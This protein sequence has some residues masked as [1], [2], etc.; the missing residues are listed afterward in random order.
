M[1]NETSA[2]EGAQ[3]ESSDHAEV[4]DD[5]ND[6]LGFLSLQQIESR[7]ENEEENPIIKIPLEPGG[8][9]DDAPSDEEGSEP[10]D[11]ENSDTDTTSSYCSIWLHLQ[12][13]QRAL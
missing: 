3:F 6:L 9:D 8:K 5:I 2:E 12:P 10:K 1:G 4:Q 11:V 7:A 13:D